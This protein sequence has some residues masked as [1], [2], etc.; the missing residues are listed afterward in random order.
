MQLSV[1]SVRLSPSLDEIQKSINKAAMIVMK[2]A[3]VMWDWDTQ[4]MAEED[5]PTFYDRITRDVEIV[6]VV[7]LLTGAV[8]G[9][10]SQVAEYLAQFHRYDW[11]WKDDMEV[12]Y[13]KFIDKNP[14]IEDFEGELRK[15]L[16]VEK[17]INGIPPMHNIGALSLNTQNLKLQL[18]N[19]C[20]QW[21]VQYSDKVHQQAHDS[22]DRLLE[23]IR[24][25]TNKLERE[26]ETLEDLRFVMGVLKEIRE[27]ESSVEMEI[28]PILDMYQMLEHYLP[29]GYMSKEEMD[30][31]SVLRSSWIHLMDDAEDVTDELGTK[32]S[33]FKQKL[34]KDVK[35]FKDLKDFNEFKDFIP[36]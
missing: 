8:H 31:R 32:S 2:I 26:V 34:L 17:D 14:K 18:R 19:E 11:L 13:R 16:L 35:D 5:R 7:L 27:R 15:F 28:T 30:S 9:L 29:P 4:D 20:R 21:K 22:M 3:Q 33:K 24:V 25:T 12:M 6:R 1:P 23:Y 36:T 10:R